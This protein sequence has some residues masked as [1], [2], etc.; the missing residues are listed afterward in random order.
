MNPQSVCKQLEAK[1]VD[2]FKIM[3]ENSSSKESF[4]GDILQM[5]QEKVNQTLD[6]LKPGWL[7]TYSNDALWGLS[8]EW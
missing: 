6:Q 5:I 1:I 4:G 7:V 3:F 2:S 8:I